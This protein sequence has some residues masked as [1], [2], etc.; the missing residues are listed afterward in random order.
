MIIYVNLS[1]ASTRFMKCEKCEHIFVVLSDIDSK[2]TLA[3]KPEP[4][5]KVQQKPPPPPKKVTT[6]YTGTTPIFWLLWFQSCLKLSVFS[7]HQRHVII[8][9]LYFLSKQKDAYKSELS[10]WLKIY[11]L[12][13]RNFVSN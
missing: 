1:P 6:L 4:P 11:N 10:V 7:D 8:I 13:S 3:D 5:E 2:K 9:R 12:I